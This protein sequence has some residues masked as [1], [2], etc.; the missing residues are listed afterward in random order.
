VDISRRLTNCTYRHQRDASE[1]IH[2][3]GLAAAHHPNDGDTRRA[4]K[5]IDMCVV[6]CE[7]KM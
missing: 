1:L 5:T 7:V 2:E 3:R 4:A 6:R